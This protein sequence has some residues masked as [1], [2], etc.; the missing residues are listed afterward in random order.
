MRILALAFILIGVGSVSAAN[1]VEA[2]KLIAKIKSVSK[3]GTGNQEAGAAWKDLVVLGGEAVFP[4]LKAL[5]D[6]APLAAN[7]LR[8][9]VGSMVE[10]QK[11]RGEKLPADQLEAFAKDTQR[12]P[13]GRRIAYE[14]LTDLDPTTP[15][16]LLP[17]MLDDPSPDLR[18][19]AIAAAMLRGE[20]LEGNASIA[21]YTRLFAFVRDQDQANAI[22]KKL[23]TEKT[24]PNVNA[25]FG[26]IEN[27]MLAGPFDSPKASAFDKVYEPEKKVDLAAKYVGKKAAEVKW[28]P[29]SA[30]EPYGMV[31]LNKAIAKHKDAVAY[32]YS[33]IEAEKETPA[34]IRLGCINAVKVFLNGKEVFARDEYHHGERFDQYMAKVTLK[35]GKNEILVK[36]CQDDQTVQWAQNWQFQ[37]RVCDATGGALPVKLMAAAPK[38]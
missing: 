38:Q 31:N 33:V 24:K 29:H 34:E 21:E 28:V 8:S 26:V 10:K 19:D 20:R 32:A 15:K 7:W 6:A 23:E 9:A 25:H 3:E 12:S 1:T 30:T 17:A 22:L 37:L 16:R 35:A 13:A 11:A 4:T 27:W 5:D 18:R 14:L 36:V 2:D